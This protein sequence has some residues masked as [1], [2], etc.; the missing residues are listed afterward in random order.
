M[1]KKMKLLFVSGV[2]A[3]ALMISLLFIPNQASA[4]GTDQMTIDSSKN[5]SMENAATPSGETKDLVYG[6]YANG[7]F[8]INGLVN[9]VVTKSGQQFTV[10]TPNGNGATT[11]TVYTVKGSDSVKPT[12]TPEQPKK[13]ETTGGNT[14][15]PKKEENSSKTQTPKKEE[16]SSKTQTAQKEESSSK[17]QTAQKEESSSKTQTAQ[18]E[19]SSSK[20][21][22]AQKEES[23][24]KTQTAQKEVKSSEYKE[25]KLPK[26]GD[27][28]TMPVKVAGA[29]VVLAGLVV[30][31]MKRKTIFSK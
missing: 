26:T 6:Y 11:L 29:L 3:L 5:T 24:S 8:V 18:K 19:E 25:S 13:E 23:S 9:E 30:A 22:T 27:D 28:N 17:T 2:S 4:Q 15:T 10:Y 20:T 21:Q 12:P 16:N 14:Q 7:Q 31:W 1:K